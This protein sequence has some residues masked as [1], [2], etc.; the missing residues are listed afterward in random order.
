MYDMKQ[1]KRSLSMVLALVMLMSLV[2]LAPATEADAATASSYIATTYAANLSVK[3][4]QATALRDAPTTSASAKYTLPANTMLSVKALHKNTSGTY[5]YEVLFYDMTLYVDATATTMVSHL[6][7]DIS[8][9]N[10]QSPA[11]LAYGNSFGI[12]GDITASLND[13]GTITA[14]MHPN[15]N[16]TRGPSLIATDEVNGKTY[17]L[18]GS[19]LDSN[20]A[21]GSMD[22][23]VY[24]Y[25]ITVEALSYYIND[26]D[27]LATSTQ[28]V[29]LETQ[30]CVITDWTNPNDDLAFGIDVST[31]QSSI[32]WSKVQY[33]VDFAILRIGYS[34]TLD[35]RFLEYAAGCEKY[36]IPY[37]VYHYSYALTGA[38]AV[39]EAEFV[40]NTLKNYGYEPQLGVWFDM[41]DSSQAALANSTKESLVTSFCDTIADAGY[42]P[43]FYGFTSWFTT[44]FQNSYLSSIPVW[45]AQIDGFSSNGTATHDGGTWLWQYSWEGSI[46]GI[47]G[48]VD[49]NLCYAD[50]SVFNSD[51]SYLSSC[52]QYPAHSMGKTT[53]SVTMRQYPSTSYTSMGTV[54]SG[55]A[56]EITGLYKNT[57][58]EYWYQV[59]KGSSYG[60]IPANNV[61]ITEMLYN[62]VAVIDPVMADNLSTGASYSLSGNL[63]SK[64]NSINT[65]YA[66]VYTGEDTQ[67]SP[68]L[69]SS[70][71]VST[72]NYRLKSS[73][74][75]NSMVFSQ[76]SSGYYT[77]EISA[78]VKN[79]YV[80]GGTLASKTQNVVLW[81]AP[82]TIGGAAITPP[83]QMVC[84]HTIVT[85]AAVA[86]TC[87][88]PG[89]TA[90]THCSK[91][92]V[93]LTAQTEIPATGHSYT[94]T[95]DK[96]T[97]TSYELF[98]YTCTKCGNKYDISADQLANW[99]E[100]KP[101]GV[102]SSQIQTKTQYRYA[103]CTSTTWQQNATNTILY[104]NSWPS[105]FS[106]SSS[107]YSQYNKKSSKVT[108]SETTTT[109]TV[110]N[111]DKVTGYLYY[112]WCYADSYY[113]VASKSGSYTTFHAYYSTTS[114]DN[115][116]C[117]TSDMSYKTSHS[118][119]SNSNWWFVTEVYG[120]EY[121]T[122]NAVP[123]GQQWGA[124]SAW[125]DT[126]YTAVANSRKVE[127]R[128][129]YRYTGATLGDHVWSNGICTACN[130]TC[131]HSY[132]NNVCTICGL[133]QASKDYYLFGYINGAD[134]GCEGDYENI[135]IYHFVNGKLTAT[136]TQASYV[137]V[138]T[139]DN[140]NWYMTNGWQGEVN[141]VK[142][143]NTSITGSSSDKMYV[144]GNVQVTFTLT[145]NSD[146]SLTLSYTTAACTHPSHNTSGNCTSCGTAVNHTYVNNTCSVCGKTLT[147]PTL[148]PNYPTVA[149]EGAI[150]LNVYYTATDLGSVTL[151]DMG[152][153]VYTSAQPN[154]TIDTASS[155]VPGAIVSGDKYVVHTNGIAAKNLGDT[156]YF[157]IYARMDDGSYVYSR[158]F[159]TSP[160]AY[161]L[162]LIGN[163]SNNSYI[164]SLCVS[165]LN[166]GAAAQQYFNYKS[167]DLMNASLTAE[168]QA[169]VSSYNASMMDPVVSVTGIKGA[170]F[171]RNTTAFTRMYPS[172]SFEGAFSINYYFV[173]GLTVD[174]NMTL[175]YWTTDTYNSVS[176]LT[177]SNAEGTIIMTNEGTRY[178]GAVSNIPAKKMDETIYVA[179]V[180]TSGGTTYTTGVIAYSL[181]YY[182]EELAANTSAD[183]ADLA[184]KTAVYGYY[185]ERYFD[186][187]A[188]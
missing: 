41:E 125:S 137:G 107:L 88:T 184:A 63:V 62:D 18:D 40:I 53:S 144:P 186:Y 164:R 51:S 129:V 133:G 121:T 85:D 44:S 124:W 99:S 161:A 112:H 58:N 111:S 49:C 83:A 169:L 170:A 123:D 81:T 115:Y 54:S 67:A 151:D 155:V 31:W 95:S 75:C 145:S 15:T 84:D 38:G 13:L 146:G 152:L 36:N 78:D 79:Y 181:G 73:A 103:N 162:T 96:A 39:D 21:F 86:A 60:Y 166:Y 187:I 69:T 100:T 158:M 147:L 135:G 87:T 188:G 113:S 106:T 119:C 168:Q 138:K 4:T 185:A 139:S 149:F 156:L 105:G 141:S 97:C 70:D 71:T 24:T 77:Y 136:F 143:Y 182:C 140:V 2:Y 19:T 150:Q 74:V 179:G 163:T 93:V 72:K 1:F 80:S 142:L 68:V 176:Q 122:Y 154:G 7:G 174:N 5:W 116:T 165:M 134:Y 160:K 29:V 47:S 22:P 55:T 92:N 23:G 180:Y 59:I 157:K 175:Y 52:T 57:A 98:H 26:S 127:T 25:V 159:S 183:G 33:D 110:I 130:T 37:G 148:T 132:S 20:L 50:F 16:I 61:T 82:F 34:T 76:L 126:V 65:T 172:I 11:S 171:T 9:D 120:Q 45:I 118:T 30:E 177:R 28:S 66:K 89:K 178:H 64:Y 32:D 42:Q 91:C 12:E 35:N 3:T 8:I 109:K 46:S 90:G 43:G 173:N 108:A 10:V 14:S 131:S 101:A 167:Y 102:P 48:D 17:S 27:A 94:A 153:L 117:D 114:P 104:V 56:V 6:T 128:T